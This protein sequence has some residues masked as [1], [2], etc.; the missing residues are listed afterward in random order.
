MIISRNT[1]AT[2]VISAITASV[3]FIP[4]RLT[5]GRTLVRRVNPWPGG[6]T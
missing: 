6:G 4:V 2:D 5:S 3:A 1:K